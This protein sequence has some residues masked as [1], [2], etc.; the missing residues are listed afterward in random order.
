V[1]FG[2][3]DPLLHQK[4]ASQPASLAQVKAQRGVGWLVAPVQ[5][6]VG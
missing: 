1:S 3:Q 4:P 5:K 6:A 2:T